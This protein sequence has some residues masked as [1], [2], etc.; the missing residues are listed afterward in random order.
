MA[1]F[2]IASS[3]AVDVG[4]YDPPAPLC[5]VPLNVGDA[6][7]NAWMSAGREYVESWMVAGIDAAEVD[8][9]AYESIRLEVVTTVDGDPFESDATVARRNRHGEAG[10]T[11]RRSSEL[12]SFS[13]PRA[14]TPEW[15]RGLSQAAR[16]RRPRVSYDIVMLARSLAVLGAI[17]VVWGCGGSGEGDPCSDDGCAESTVS[18]GDATGMTVTAGASSSE[19]ASTDG[20]S[21]DASDSGEAVPFSVLP[22]FGVVGTEWVYIHTHIS[23]SEPFESRCSI[24]EVFGWPDG[25]SGSSYVCEANGNARTSKVAL[26]EDQIELREDIGTLQPPVPL[27]QV[28]L[29]VGDAWDHEWTYDNNSVETGEQWTVSGVETVTVEAGT[30]EAV[31]LDTVLIVNGASSSG[32]QWWVDGIGRIKSESGAGTGELR[33]FS[34]P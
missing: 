6:W 15:V 10:K 18:S 5:R 1:L 23:A 20:G 17:A 27:Y 12:A 30:F 2:E 28:P 11:V 13:P 33:S 21:G 3:D 29:F 31:R 19:G 32:T 16:A 24:T 22:P 34:S 14:E 7:T 4:V 26:F 9:A 25:A 8:A